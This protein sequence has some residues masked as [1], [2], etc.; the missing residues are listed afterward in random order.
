MVYFLWL[1]GDFIDLFHKWFA[2]FFVDFLGILKLKRLSLYGRGPFLPYFNWYSF[3]FAAK[4]RTEGERIGLWYPTVEMGGPDGFFLWLT[5][6]VCSLLYS[7]LLLLCELLVLGPRLLIFGDDAVGREAFCEW[8]VYNC[9]G[10]RMVGRFGDSTK[11]E[12]SERWCK[13]GC[14]FFSPYLFIGPFFLSP[15]GGFSLSFFLRDFSTSFLTPSRSLSY[16]FWKDQKS[17]A[18]NAFF[19]L[20]CDRPAWKSQCYF[21]FNLLVFTLSQYHLPCDCC[22]CWFTLLR[23]IA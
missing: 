22:F 1:S 11:G 12:S 4:L 6:A 15:P 18:P 14:D 19:V 13:L 17:H 20:K 7:S 5:G 23:R 21:F 10:G 8:V 9:D 2:S 3:H 16:F